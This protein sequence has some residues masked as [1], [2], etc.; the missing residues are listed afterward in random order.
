MKKIIFIL[1]TVTTVLLSCQKEIDYQFTNSDTLPVVVTNSVTSISD[2]M[3]T[4]GG[5]VTADGG[6]PIIARG[7]CWGT[8]PNPSVTGN[9]STDGTGLGLFVHTITGLLP[10]TTYHVRAY[11]T[12][13]VGTAY[14]SDSSFTTTN[15]PAVLPAVTTTTISSIT[16]TT[17]SGGGNV[18]SDG[19]ATVITRGVCWNTSPNP[20]V[21]GTHTSDGSGT[22]AF[23]SNIIGL[24][25]ST[26]Y[27]VRAYATNSAGTAY[28]GDSAFMTA[29]R[30]IYVAGY[31]DNSTS[32]SAILWKNG[33]ATVLG[34]S[35]GMANAVFVSGNDVYVG[36]SEVSI[37][38]VGF[39][40]Y[41]KIWKNGV[42]TTL[43]VDLSEIYSVFVSGTDVYAAGYE[44]AGGMNRATIWKNGVATH[45][46]NGVNNA[47]A[48]SVF[49]NGTDI[50]I[51]G[52]D[53]FGSKIWK[54]GIASSVNGVDA[55]N[56]VYV[57]GSD[58][59]V[60][61]HS[62]NGTTQDIAM[63]W[64]N[65]VSTAL[66]N[67]IKYADAK[68]VFVSG[69][70]VYVTGFENSGTSLNPIVAKIWKNGTQMILTGTDAAGNAITISDGNVY[71][72]GTANLTATGIAKVWKDGV[73]TTLS[74]TAN[75][76]EALSIFVK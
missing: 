11:A 41:A 23:V 30:D 42:A 61:G 58:I 52:N 53:G 17:A 33:V 63:V 74:N 24:S 67:G 27:H 54:N 40:R 4:G 59:Y 66:T 39:I 22:G 45:L 34:T 76:A 15:G 36:G 49:V 1:L 62:N 60:A 16:A 50:Y 7:L 18:I 9:H 65:G 46:S 75:N 44:S 38:P 13:N 55:P 51:T 56:A 68:S 70:D 35:I 71:V 72:A 21:T 57:L 47:L 6:S 25:P 64:K 69:T 29:P 2:T 10:S 20:V 14:G 37:G 19:G 5:K 48:S 31:E 73:S 28:G 32:R 12:N 3:A 26:T 8:A 43:G